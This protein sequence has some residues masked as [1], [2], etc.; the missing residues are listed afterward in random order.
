MSYAADC[1]RELCRLLPAARYLSAA[2]LAFWLKIEHRR[3]AALLAIYW[4]HH[5]VE[6]AHERDRISNKARGGWF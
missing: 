2:E 6:A 3:A 1:Y 5:P 4:R